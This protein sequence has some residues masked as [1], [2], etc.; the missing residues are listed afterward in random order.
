MIRSSSIILHTAQRKICLIK[1][2]TKSCI[3]FPGFWGLPGGRQEAGE[4]PKQCAVRELEE[5]LSVNVDKLRLLSVITES[6]KI[7]GG[8][9]HQLSCY[10]I[11]Y[12]E[13]F[14]EIIL[15]E[16]QRFDF[17]SPR[18]LASKKVVPYDLLFIKLFL[19]HVLYKRQMTPTTVGIYK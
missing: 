8:R 3:Y 14:S 1:R 13:N 7:L 16:G 5:E 15:K 10:Y 6:S 17:F 9:R 2:D 4:T 11:A 19:N 18:E 12:R